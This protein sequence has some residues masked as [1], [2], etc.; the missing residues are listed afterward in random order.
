MGTGPHL[1]LT[2]TLTLFQSWGRL[3]P[4]HKLVST[5][6]FDIDLRVSETVEGLKILGRM[7]EVVIE[8]LLSK[9]VFLTKIGLGRFVNGFS[10]WFV[11]F[12]FR[13]A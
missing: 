3:G 1:F 9:K 2:E 12:I 5:N 10:K 4:L 8:G 7:G 11:Y 13:Y 6:I